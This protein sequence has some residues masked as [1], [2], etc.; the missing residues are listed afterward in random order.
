MSEEQEARLLPGKPVA[1]E[2][3]ADVAQ[4]AEKLRAAGVQP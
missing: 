2:V 1:D 4:R 3:L